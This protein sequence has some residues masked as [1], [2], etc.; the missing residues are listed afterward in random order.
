[1]EGMGLG[2]EMV[3]GANQLLVNL[4]NLGDRYYLLMRLHMALKPFVLVWSIE[5][6]IGNAAIQ[7]VVGDQRWKSG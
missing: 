1:M 7:K 4:V 6:T 2:W 3:I 5:R